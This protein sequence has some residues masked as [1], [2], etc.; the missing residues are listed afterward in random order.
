MDS[1]SNAT[2]IQATADLGFR[3][4][5]IC[6]ACNKDSKYLKTRSKIS[7]AL[8]VKDV[9]NNGILQFTNKNNVL[10]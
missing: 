2:G 5:S 1:A 3:K 7:K 4:L 8:I 10:I 9:T 6:A